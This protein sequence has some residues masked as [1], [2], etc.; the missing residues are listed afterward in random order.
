MVATL[1]IVATAPLTTTARALGAAAAL[2]A[3][4]ILTVGPHWDRPLLASG[5]YLYAPYVP[6]ELD[7][8]TQLKAGTL[9][10]DRDGAAATVSVKR[11]TGTTTL[12]VDGKVDA[13]NRSD[14][15]T[16]KLLAHLPLL[17]HDNARDVAVIGLG[18]GVTVGA[19]L[20]H[21]VARVD[22]V[23]LSPEVIEA[24]TFLRQRQ[25]ACAC[26]CPHAPDCR[27]RTVASAAGFTTVRRRDLRAVKSVDCRRRGA[28]HSRILPGGA[29]PAGAA[30]HHLP[31]GTYLQHRRSRSPIDR[32]NIHLGFSQ[33]HPVVDRWR[34]CAAGGIPTIATT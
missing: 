7:L 21:P 24:S 32:R 34:R 4:L 15:L 13:S 6:K 9:L 11:L 3:G 25:S 22:V 27:R 26:R 19:A 23:E 2:A 12:A 17:L 31:V 14:M 28:L 5:A 16:Q 8:E 1:T 20:R 29:R 33:R 18:S 10:Y 30:R